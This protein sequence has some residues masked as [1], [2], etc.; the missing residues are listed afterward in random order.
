MSSIA[1][2]GAPQRRDRQAGQFSG[3]ASSPAEG[4]CD[5]GETI[6]ESPPPTSSIPTLPSSQPDLQR[7][8]CPLNRQ[9]LQMPDIPAMATCRRKIAVRTQRGLQPR[10]GDHPPSV[11]TI[12]A[13]D[14]HT[15]SQSPF[16][17]CCHA[18]STQLA[19]CRSSQFRLTQSEEDPQLGGM[20]RLG[21]S[22]CLGMIVKAFYAFV[23]RQ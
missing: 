16:R 21:A 10:G 12:G 13:Q 20:Q 22:L 6:G 2:L 23:K 4:S 3:P 8:G 1:P 15:R 7:H 11:H 5:P 9:I 17:F 14:L 18:T 19:F